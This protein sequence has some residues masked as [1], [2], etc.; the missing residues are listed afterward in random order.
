MKALEKGVLLGGFSPN[1]IRLGPALT[2]TER[3]IDQGVD[4]LDYALSALDPECE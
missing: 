3:E 1:C 2:V 4:A